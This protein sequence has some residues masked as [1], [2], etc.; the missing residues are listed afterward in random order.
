[1]KKWRQYS[2][3]I[4]LFVAVSG[5]LGWAALECCSRRLQQPHE[6]NVPN[7]SSESESPG[8][9]ADRLGI[10]SDVSREARLP[11][12]SIAQRQIRD[13]QVGV[14]TKVPSPDF[15]R[16]ISQGGEHKDASSLIVSSPVSVELSAKDAAKWQEVVWAD[17]HGQ[18]IRDCRKLI[19]TFS[20][21][22]NAP[23]RVDDGWSEWME[24]QLR[25]S[26]NAKAGDY[27]STKTNAKCISDA[28]VFVLYADSA[29]VIF[30]SGYQ[31]SNDFHRWLRE[32]PWNEWL[33]VHERNNGNRSTLEWRV[34]GSLGAKPFINW[35][36]VTRKE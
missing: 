12:E 2:A 16:T 1:M 10:A 15:V 22:L 36:I 26:L 14:D 31:H 3:L 20:R 11:V 25:D 35:Y 19:D 33:E 5:V 28:C 30:D 27:Q 34:V 18:G 21:V 6:G 8:P 32:Q 24:E 29:G 17:C 7:S 13:H 23:G 9:E 4:F